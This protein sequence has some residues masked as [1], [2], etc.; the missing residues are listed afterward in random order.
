MLKHLLLT[1][2]TIL[3][4]NFQGFSQESDPRSAF[5]EKWRN[6][7]KYLLEIAESVPETSLEFR[8]TER[9][10]SVKEQLLH[11]RANMLWLG[12]T[13]FNASSAELPESK[14]NPDSKEELIKAL[15]ESFECVG[16]LVKNTDDQTLKEEVEF[17]AG[18]KSRLQ[19]LNLLQDHVTHHRGQLIVYLNLMEIAPPRYIGW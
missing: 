11:I 10:M 18:P 14:I 1:L 4:F 17:F 9:Q 16:G 13:Y 2:L 3:I 19:I 15:N 7:S 6:S 8:P 5:L 12:S